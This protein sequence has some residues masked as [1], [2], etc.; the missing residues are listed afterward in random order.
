MH[1][2]YLWDLSN[3]NSLEPCITFTRNDM[4]KLILSLPLSFQDRSMCLDLF[5]LYYKT[6]FKYKKKIKKS[7]MEQFC[8][9]YH[10]GLLFLSL[11]VGFLLAVFTFHTLRMLRT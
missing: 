5:L 3:G 6:H 10:N 1:L 2:E 7:P 4:I 8:I 9:R 11:V